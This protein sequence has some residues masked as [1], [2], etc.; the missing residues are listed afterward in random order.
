MHGFFVFLLIWEAK[1]TNIVICGFKVEDL[2]LLDCPSRI[3]YRRSRAETI[4]LAP[5][6]FDFHL[7]PQFL[8]PASAFWSA[9]A[10]Q[11]RSDGFRGFAMGLIRSTQFLV[12]GSIKTLK[13]AKALGLATQLK[14]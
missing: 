4:K 6:A 12:D 5:P 11:R 7:L 14:R 1:Q 3:G 10:A 13:V 8:E 2:T 9:F